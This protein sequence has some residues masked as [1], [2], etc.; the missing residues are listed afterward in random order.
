M[1]YYAV[2]ARL[3]PNPSGIIRELVLV[4]H[5]DHTIVQDHKVYPQGSP[6]IRII[7][8]R[9]EDLS[10]GPLI[11]TLDEKLPDGRHF[12]RANLELTGCPDALVE[13]LIVDAYKYNYT[14]IMRQVDGRLVCHYFRTLDDFSTKERGGKCR[15]CNKD[16]QIIGNLRTGFDKFCFP[17][18]SK[19]KENNKE[20]MVLSSPTIW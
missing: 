6:S 9:P 15:C 1:I 13:A 8:L 11:C 2:D 7:A 14:F 19:F 17:S 20:P 12:L 5:N 3:V 10:N 18:C 16:L 4:P